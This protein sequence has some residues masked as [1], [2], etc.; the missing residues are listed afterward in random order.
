MFRLWQH[1]LSWTFDGVEMVN[2][3]SF[4]MTNMLR[5]RIPIVLCICCVEKSN[6]YSDIIV[7]IIRSKALISLGQD[8]QRCID[9]L[10]DMC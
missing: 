10:F 3:D 7:I 5:S 2:Y 4:E 8:S 6:Y 1:I 9:G